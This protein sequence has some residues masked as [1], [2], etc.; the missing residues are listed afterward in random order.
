M[1]ILA[2]DVE[3]ANVFELLSVAP[4]FPDVDSKEVRQQPTATMPI[5]MNTAKTN[6]A[7][8]ATRSSPQ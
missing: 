7:A 8:V 6:G 2:A 3:M 5:A 1:C 4:N